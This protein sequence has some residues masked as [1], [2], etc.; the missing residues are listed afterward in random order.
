MAKTS[1][2][3]RILRDN[4]RTGGLQGFANN[5]LNDGKSRG[6]SYELSKIDRTVKR[7]MNKKGISLETDIVTIKDNTVL[8]YVSH[9]KRA[10]GAAIDLNKFWMVEKAVTKPNHIYEDTKQNQLVYVYSSRYTKGK[11]LKVVI[12][13]NYKEKGKVYNILK[14]IGVVAKEDMNGAQYRKIK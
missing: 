3:I 5:V 1:G 10:K 8:K 2:G 4:K 14:S 6:R 7:D 13:P 11:T 9:P 12:Q